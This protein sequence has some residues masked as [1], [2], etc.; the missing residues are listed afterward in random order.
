MGVSESHIRKHILS[1]YFSLRVGMGIIGFALPPLLWVI[2]RLLEGHGL[3]PSM[4]AYYHSASRDVFVG[5]LFAIGA[6]AYLYKGYTLREN[7]AMNLAGLCAVGVAIFPTDCPQVI[8]NIV[9]ET[10]TYKGAHTLFAII[11]FL[12]IAY[13]CIFL[14]NDTL[15]FVS[16]DAKRKRYK[17]TYRTIGALMVLLPLLVFIQDFGYMNIAPGKTTLFWMEALAIWSFA[18]F[19]LLK[20]REIKE[21]ISNSDGLTTNILRI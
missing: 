17:L 4:S 2:A 14:S 5:S 18:A 16:N 19:W 8:T 12:L 7:I 9:C 20:S 21:T 1:S 11:F 3:L 15:K 6:A 10:P 13:V